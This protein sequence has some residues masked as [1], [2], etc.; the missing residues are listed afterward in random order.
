MTAMNVRNPIRCF[1]SF[2]AEQ[3]T[4]NV[5][6]CGRYRTSPMV[7]L[8]HLHQKNIEHYYENDLFPLTSDCE[9]C[10]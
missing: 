5:Y 10:L 1:C 6:V 4:D 3:T 2:V 7:C 9:M 8:F